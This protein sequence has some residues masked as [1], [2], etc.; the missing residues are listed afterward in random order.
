MSFTLNGLGLVR[1]RIL[2]IMGAVCVSMRK[3]G[4]HLQMQKNIISFESG[5]E[6]WGGG[7]EEGVKAE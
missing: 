5:L 7:E 2:Y 3:D 4:F 1:P 6:R